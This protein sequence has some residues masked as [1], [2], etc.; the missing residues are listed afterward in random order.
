M[1]GVTALLVV[2]D[3]VLGLAR[4]AGRRRALAGLPGAVVVVVASALAYALWFD[5]N[6]GSPEL[7]WGAVTM[8]AAAVL[9]GAARLWDRRRVS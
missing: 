3:A 2:A 9:V 5:D 7:L 1:A 6:A 8:A 4:S